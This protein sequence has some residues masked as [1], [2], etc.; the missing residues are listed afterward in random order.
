MEKE[1]RRRI[2]C[3]LKIAYTSQ[4]RGRWFVLSVVSASSKNRYSSYTLRR[5]HIAAVALWGYLF[6]NQTLFALFM[7]EYSMLYFAE[8]TSFTIFAS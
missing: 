7:A 6:A 2:P 8:S 1:S 5:K 3:F 4:R